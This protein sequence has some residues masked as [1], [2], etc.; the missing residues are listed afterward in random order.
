MVEMKWDG[1]RLLGMR[2]K[3]LG[4]TDLLGILVVP[5]SGGQYFII[6]ANGQG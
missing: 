1:M 6:C 2:W 3:E 5:G 4:A